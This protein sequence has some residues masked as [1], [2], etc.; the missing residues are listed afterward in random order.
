MGDTYRL[1]LLQTI[2]ELK[3]VQQLEREVWQMDPIPVHQ[4]LTAIKNGGMILGGFDQDKLVGF[5]YGFPG[6]AGGKVHLCSHM[7]GILPAY[8]GRGLGEALKWGQRE[9]ALAQGY[10]LITWTFDPLES[11]NGYLN[12]GKL[13]GIS[14]TYVRDCYGSMSD[15]LNHGLPSDRLLVE[16]WI[17]SP[18]VK[19]RPEIPPA[20]EADLQEVAWKLTEQGYPYLTDD[21]V[22]EV[23]ADKEAAYIPIPVQF[24]Q[25]KRT[26]F[27]LAL[28]WRLK[29]RALMETLFAKGYVAAGVVRL[30]GQPVQYY[31][32]VKRD[33][34]TIDF[35]A[36]TV[37]GRETQP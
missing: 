7:L 18:H 9:W 28:D 15:A 19:E 24:Q 21:V 23:H 13:R 26:D 8:R 4:T 11:V 6:F 1:K 37:E 32:A 29:T 25:L 12:F 22:S 36:N 30:P 17:D 3:E 2:D 34:L 33:R 35:T 20:D 10:R 14:Q 5:N 16:W 31:A 27:S